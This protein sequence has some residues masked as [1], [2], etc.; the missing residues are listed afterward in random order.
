VTDP[1]DCAPADPSAIAVPDEV[2]HLAWTNASVLTWDSLAA[3][4]GS[5]TVYDV[6][7][8]ML[9]DVASFWP[10]ASDECV[11]SES[12]STTVSDTSPQ[13]PPGR[14]RYFLVRGKNACGAG[15]LATASNG[16][17]RVGVACP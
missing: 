4:S 1:C 10:A 2:A 17:D 5:S 9:D 11:A 7:S 16:R 3:T 13:P 12:A 14:G 8:G 15:R 6:V